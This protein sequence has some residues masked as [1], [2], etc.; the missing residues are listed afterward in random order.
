MSNLQ[1]IEEALQLTP[2]D[3]FLAI[4]TLLKSLDKPDKELENIW[5]DESEKRLQLYK[6][7]SSKT[8]SFDE[9]FN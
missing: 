7:E 4:E 1:I 9:V 5:E 6:K 3:K 8:I 2:K